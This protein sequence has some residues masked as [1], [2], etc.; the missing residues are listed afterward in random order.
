MKGK[1]KWDSKTHLDSHGRILSRKSVS[2]DGL[3]EETNDLEVNEK[4]EGFG[5]VRTGETE[6]V[7]LK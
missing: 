6:E 5:E 1:R 3:D 2:E 7:G 4:L